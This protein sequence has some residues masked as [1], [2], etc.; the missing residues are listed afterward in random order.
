VIGGSV[1][2]SP[3]G[4]GIVADLADASDVRGEAI[5]LGNADPLE[6]LTN[7]NSNCAGH[8]LSRLRGQLSG[9]A[10]GLLVLD[11]QA[12]G[13]ILPSMVQIIFTNRR[14]LRL[15]ATPSGAAYAG[16]A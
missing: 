4:G 1:W 6:P 13:G 14:N 9:E 15:S 7:R 5:G 11:V 8:R 12:H 10:L 2:L 16:E 3:S